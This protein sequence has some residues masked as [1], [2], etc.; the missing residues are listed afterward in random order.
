MPDDASRVLAPPEPSPSLYNENYY[1]DDFGVPY[2]RTEHWI[3]FFGNVASRIGQN[4]APRTALDAG[5]AMGLLVE[6]LVRVGIDAYGI[7]I[8]DFAIERAPEVVRDR[9]RVGSITEPIEGRYDLVLCVEVLEHLTRADS[10]TAMDNLCAVTSTILF[11]STPMHYGQVTHVNVNPPEVWSEMF[12]RRG[13]YRDL[14]QDATFLA[15]WA[16]VYRKSDGRTPE[17]VRSYDRAFWRLTDEVTQ[18]RNL[19][20]SM[21]QD[22]DRLTDEVAKQPDAAADVVDGAEYRRLHD[23]LIQTSATLLATRD[24]LAG[25]EASVGQTLGEREYWHSYSASRENAFTQYETMRNSKAWRA[26]SSALTPY[27][28]LVGAVRRA[29][30]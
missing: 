3:R 30:R 8:S 21:Q 4:L 2:E 11:S 6:Q 1:K 17:V 5:C 20:L 9:C 19:V 10:E 27:R 13:F 28:R 14:D 24:L 26:F 7:D 12:A 25:L 15:P 22:I 29:R 16:T 18:L 23:E